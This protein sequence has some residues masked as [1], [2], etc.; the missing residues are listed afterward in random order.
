[1]R[2]RTFA[3]KQMIKLMKYEQN[4]LRTKEGR[5]FLAIRVWTGTRLEND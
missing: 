4:E 5:N 2:F 3:F 1:M